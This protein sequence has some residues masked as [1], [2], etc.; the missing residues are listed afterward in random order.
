MK[1]AIFALLF[2]VC[3]ALFACKGKTPA[4]E[5]TGAKEETSAPKEEVPMATPEEGTGKWK[6]PAKPD[7]DASK[8]YIATI[9]TAKGNIK[10]ELFPKEAPL[11]VTNFMQLAQKNFYNNLTFHRVVPGFVVQG[12]DPEGT[13]MGGPGYTIPAEIGLPHKEGA[14]AWARLPETGPDGSPVNPKKRS[15]GSQFYITLSPQPQLDG[16]YTVFGQTVE[17]MDIVRKIQR[18]DQIEGVEVEVR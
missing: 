6:G 7:V 11:S 12:G 2:V 9:K 1:K 4:A 15:S 10:V 14:F 5:E 17:G 13:G 3:C 8:K 18:G 16:G